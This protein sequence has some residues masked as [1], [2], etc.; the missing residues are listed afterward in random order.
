[1]DNDTMLLQLKGK[2]SPL[3][4]FQITILAHKFS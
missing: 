3:H 2:S 4:V 1:M